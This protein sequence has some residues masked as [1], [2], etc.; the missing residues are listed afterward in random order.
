MQGSGGGPESCRVKLQS[1][2]AWKFLASLK[3]LI[4]LFKVFLIRVGAKLCSIVAL[5][6]SQNG[7]L[8]KWTSLAANDPR[9]K[10]C[11]LQQRMG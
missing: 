2:L 5:Q 9:V 10:I 11:L 8:L 4:S 3:T 1:A 7:F 6:E